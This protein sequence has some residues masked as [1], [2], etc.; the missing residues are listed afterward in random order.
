VDWTHASNTIAVGF[1]PAGCK[2]QQ[3]GNGACKPLA[4]SHPPG[5]YNENAVSLRSVLGAQYVFGIQNHGAKAES[6]AYHVVVVY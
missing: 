4:Y 3:F 1:Y 5:T 2:K 6:G